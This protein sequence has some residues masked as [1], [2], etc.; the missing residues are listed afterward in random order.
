[1]NACF[2]SSLLINPQ[3]EL[4]IAGVDEVGR[5]CI[6]G[7]VV[8]AAVVLPLSDIPKLV[9]LGIKDSKKLSAK[10]RNE[11]VEPIQQVVS[12]WQ[13]AEA[14]VGEIDSLNIL[15][16]SLLAM[17]RAVVALEPI[18]EMCL[19]DGSFKIRD[20]KLNQQTI[21]KGDNLSSAIASASI[22]AK[23]WRDSAIANLAIQYPEYDLVSN[24]GYP[25]QKHRLAIQT[26]GI[27]DLHRKTF[28][29][30]RNVPLRRKSD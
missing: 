13:V 16:A 9:E 7:S 1:M 20:L 5:G 24:K 12:G 26:Y 22:L 25:T 23:V 29:P 15:Q 8:A 3:E 18:P 19:I 4:L 6:F 27:C 14:S 21:V 10:K 11:L 17:K 28:A 2:E 30:C